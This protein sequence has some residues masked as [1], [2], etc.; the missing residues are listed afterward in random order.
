MHRVGNFWYSAYNYF[1]RDDRSIGKT[2]PQVWYI[3]ESNSLN[4]HS[5][6]Y[7]IESRLVHNRKRG[8]EGEMGTIVQQQKPDLRM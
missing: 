4:V 1:P 2:S 3:Y 7:Q 5:T 6:R 8:M